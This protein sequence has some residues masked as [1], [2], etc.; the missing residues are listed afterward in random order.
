MRKITYAQATKAFPELK[1]IKLDGA[2]DFDTVSDV[3]NSRNPTYVWPI[4]NALKSRMNSMVS[5]ALTRLF[6][7]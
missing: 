6:E 7:D 2:T 5:P 1:T 3:I 4:V